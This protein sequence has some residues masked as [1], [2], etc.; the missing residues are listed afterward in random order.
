MLE[1]PLDQIHN[2]EDLKKAILALYHLAMEG[3]SA[4]IERW[5]KNTAYERGNYNYNKQPP[6]ITNSRGKS[7]K[8]MQKDIISPKLDNLTALLSRG[9]PSIQIEALSADMQATFQ[10]DG[11]WVRAPYTNDVPAQLLQRIM[12][13]EWR[14]R[15][16]VALKKK[17]TRESLIS[18]VAFRSFSVQR[19][20]YRGTKIYTKLLPRDQILLDPETTKLET[21]EDCR[22]MFLLSNMTASDIQNKWGL[23]EK[24]YASTET[25]S[26]NYSENS[27]AVRLYDQIDINGNMKRSAEMNTYPVFVLLWKP[28]SPNILSFEDDNAKQN[29]LRGRMYVIVNK[30]KLAYNGFAQD[31][32]GFFPVV[33]YCHSPINNTFSGNS[34]VESLIGPQDMVNILYNIAAQNARSRGGSQW[35]AEPGAIKAKNFVLG[36]SVVIPVATNALSGGK[37]KELTPGD[38]GASVYNFMQSETA[39]SRELIGDPSGTLAGVTNPAV[40]SGKHAATILESSNTLMA[41]HIANLDVAHEQSAL[42]EALMIQN[43]IDLNHEYYQKRYQTWELP[44]ISEAMQELEFI[45]EILSKSNLPATTI[46]AEL[47]WYMSLYDRGLMTAYDYLDNAE[48]LE[49]LDAQFVEKVKEESDNAVPGIPAALAAELTMQRTAQAQQANQQIA[50]EIQGGSIGAD[51]MGGDEDV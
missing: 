20:L 22:Y 10:V 37:I 14:E 44:A 49:L 6:P 43:N 29:D 1:K 38:I 23:K 28:G 48:M 15:K 4:A 8:S 32:K 3:N 12:Q 19:D 21:F 33:A 7:K 13:G 40:K 36:S 16:E 24:D 46:S 27:G 41:H 50:T 26:R 25:Q 11:R 18:G 31:L 34:T 45:V 2:E 51:V 17:V 5:R 30:E 39:A 42:I 47:N 9:M 35:M